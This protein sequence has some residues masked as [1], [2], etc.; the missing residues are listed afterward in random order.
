[1]KDQHLVRG[2]GAQMVPVEGMFRLPSVED[3]FYTWTSQQ[4]LACDGS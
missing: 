3:S 2:L 1:M 4:L